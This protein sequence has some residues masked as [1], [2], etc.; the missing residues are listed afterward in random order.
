MNNCGGITKD[1]DK[2]ILDIPY[3]VTKKKIKQKT[4]FITGWNF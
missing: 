3:P 2:N 1:S 4:N